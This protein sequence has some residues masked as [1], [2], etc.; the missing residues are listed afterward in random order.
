MA[1]TAINAYFEVNPFRFSATQPSLSVAKH[2]G[3]QLTEG[4]N[5]DSNFSQPFSL[6]RRIELC[7]LMFEDVDRWLS[8]DELPEQYLICK[9]KHRLRLVA[10]EL[11]A[12][13]SLTLFLCPVRMDKAPSD[14]RLG[15]LQARYN[16]TYYTYVYPSTALVAA[17][18]TRIVPFL[19][20][21]KVLQAALAHEAPVFPDSVLRE[22]DGLAMT[23][24]EV[25]DVLKQSWQ[26]KILVKKNGQ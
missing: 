25:A 10:R 17:I 18:A 5:P 1:G 2:S 11:Q 23:A 19:R 9:I 8:R 15:S 7:C 6:I 13:S 16:G 3:P 14:H 26:P 12:L 22:M 24:G 21:P 20:T 4:W